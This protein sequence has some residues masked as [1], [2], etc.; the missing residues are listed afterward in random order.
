MAKANGQLSAATQSEVKRGELRK[1]YVKQVEHGDVGDF[2]RMSNAELEGMLAEQM[3]QLAELKPEFVAEQMR[4]L[5]KHQAEFVAED[6]R[7]IVEN[8]PNFTKAPLG[9]ACRGSETPDGGGR[10]AGI[11]ETALCRPTSIRRFC[12]YYRNKKATARTRGGGVPGRKKNGA[13]SAPSMA[14]S[15]A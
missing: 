3:R 10:V 15:P 5:A 11:F 9:Q 6:M 1:F 7:Q 2:S 12:I 4:Q 13:G 8:D 14:L